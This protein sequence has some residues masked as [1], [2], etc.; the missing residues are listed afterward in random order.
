MPAQDLF[1]QFDLNPTLPGHADPYPIFRAVREADPVHW[2]E[3]ARIW[4]VMRYADA[5]TV[6][7]HPNLSRQAYLDQLEAKSGPQ[8]I[9]AMQRH[10]LVFMDNPHHEQLRHALSEA[11]NADAIRGMK[12]SVDSFVESKLTPLL[13][14]DQ[15]DLVGD[16]VGRLPTGIAAMWLGV[17]EAEREEIVDWIFP[18]VSGRGVVRDPKTTAAANQAATE[19]RTYFQK[20]IDQRR[21]KPTD[22]LVSRLLASQAKEPSLVSDDDLISIII[23]VFGGG[24]TPGVALI[25][26]TMLNLMQSPEQLAE[27]RSNP[28]L[29]PLAVEEGLRYNTPTQAPNP[30]VAI[31]DVVVAGKTIQ[32]GQSVTVILAAANRD[33]EAFPDPERFNIHRTPNHHLAFSAGAHYCIGAMMMRME[34]V[35]I[36]GALVQRLSQPRLACQ[37]SDLKWTPHDRFRVLAA[38]P[39]AFGAR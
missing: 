31:E 27:L 6:L 5:Q 36:L 11:F 25:A 13:A 9:I 22:D 34:A 14:R 26:M 10:E 23:G 21:A 38:M 24:H 4:A 29:L 7:K 39:V 18:L 19:L 3:A 35:S 1:A 16:F 17:P 8:P 28:A 12:A 33:P 37:V 32:K 2:C 15:F 30:L 20:L